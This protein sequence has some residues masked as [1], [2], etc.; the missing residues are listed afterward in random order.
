MPGYHRAR[1]GWWAYLMFHAPVAKSVPSSNEVPAQ[2]V[3]RNIHLHRGQLT[4]Y[5][6]DAGNPPGE[7]GVA[8][9]LSKEHAICTGEPRRDG[10]TTMPDQF[11]DSVHMEVS[12]A[13]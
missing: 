8:D 3:R 5:E 1:A 2:I 7:D 13:R 12:T 9:G 4:S 10:L 11:A 6:R